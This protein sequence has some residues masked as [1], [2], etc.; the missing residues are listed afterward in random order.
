ML[1]QGALHISCWEES[2]LSN[3]VRHDPVEGLNAERQEKCN[4]MIRGLVLELQRISDGD[5]VNNTCFAK[6]NPLLCPD[7]I[8]RRSIVTFFTFILLSREVSRA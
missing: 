1:L 8:Q 7:S 2:A 6:S 4:R 5:R 3:C